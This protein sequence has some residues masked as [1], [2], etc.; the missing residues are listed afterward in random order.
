MPG[1]ALPRDL[2]A[3]GDVDDVDGEVGEL[4]AEG[5]GEVVAAGFDQQQ[6]EAGE[7]AGHLAHG[8]EVDRGV[9]AD[10]GVRAAA[11]L[12]AHDALG[13]QGAG[14][15]EQ[16]LVLLGVDVVGDHGHVPA[17]AHG[18]AQDL[19][20]HGLAGADRAADAD[21]ERAVGVRCS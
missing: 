18:L 14:D 8:G 4:G 7:A 21:A 12:D 6:L 19:A 17:V 2:L 16:A 20:Q 9:L 15:G 3:A 10:R 1:P 11:G 5:G 13:R